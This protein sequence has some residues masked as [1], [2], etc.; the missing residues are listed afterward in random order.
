M[1]RM[2]RLILLFMAVYMVSYITRINYAAIIAEIVRETGRPKAA[3]TAALTGCSV[4]YG[5]GQFLSGYCGGK[6]R[7]KRLILQECL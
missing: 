1:G 2:N 6:F 3:L 4:F 5:A 7:P